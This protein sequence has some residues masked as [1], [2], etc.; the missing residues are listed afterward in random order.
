MSE[1]WCSLTG[2]A[3]LM[4]IAFLAAFWAATVAGVS[5]HARAAEPLPPTVAPPFDPAELGPA[6]ALACRCDAEGS[7]SGY[8]WEG[9]GG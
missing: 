2:V 1:P 5:R 8:E 9:Y 7:L 3:V 6:E 4:V